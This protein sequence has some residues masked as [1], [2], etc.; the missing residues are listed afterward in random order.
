MLVKDY[1]YIEHHGI[2]GMKWGI[3]RFRNYDGT[4]TSIGKKR[5]SEAAKANGADKNIVSTG[6]TSSLKLPSDPKVAKLVNQWDKIIGPEHRQADGSYIVPAGKQI[7]KDIDRVTTEPMKIAGYDHC[8]KA[9]VSAF[10]SLNASDKKHIL[11]YV[12]G[13]TT[14]ASLQ[15]MLRNVQKISTI[16]MS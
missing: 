3:R 8:V 10:S 9:S 13:M 5:Y 16:V 7:D 6:Q 12:N 2:K 4:L 15:V 14:I 11:T 1:D